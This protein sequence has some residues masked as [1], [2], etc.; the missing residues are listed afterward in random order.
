MM[1]EANVADQKPDPRTAR[2]Q[3]MLGREPAGSPLRMI[4]AA[5]LAAVAGETAAARSDLSRIVK[6]HAAAAIAN[7]GLFA[8]ALHLAVLAL[9]A[10]AASDLVRRRWGAFSLGFE[11]GRQTPEVVRWEIGDH[12]QSKLWFDVAIHRFRN[13]DS[14]IRRLSAVMQ[15]LT[16]YCLGHPPEA[17]E[18]YLNLADG[19]QIPGLAFC[20]NR[21]EYFLAPDPNFL[22]TEGYERM[23]RMVAKHSVVWEQ[24]IPI[25]FWRGSTGGRVADPAIGWRSLPR[26]RLCMLG[27]DHPDLMDAGLS[28]TAQ[29]H[30]YGIESEDE[31]RATG[32]M[33]AYV[34][35]AEAMKFKYQ[36][37]IDG[38]VNSWPGLFQKLL[39]GNPVLKVASP[40]GYRQWYYDRL[41]PW[42]NFVPV[43]SDMSDLVEKIL[44]LRSH[45][46]QARRIGEAGKQ[47][48]DSLDY[49]GEILRAGGTIDDALRHFR[50]DR[51]RTRFA[52]EARPV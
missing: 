12:R 26:I 52:P 13:S 41:E 32:L 50:R 43:A 40:Y 45:D 2:L 20:D 35:D 9:D 51:G 46:D 16:A 28:A 31:V 8:E 15:L 25:A 11:D 38:N 23:R 24:R 34:P 14:T 33:R 22:L 21:P 6:E 18:L 17:A 19:G 10:D 5:Q 3:R 4:V 27:R 39:T 37:D 7:E 1:V 42:R 49:R 48:A 44:W 29:L 36:I 30:V 47:L